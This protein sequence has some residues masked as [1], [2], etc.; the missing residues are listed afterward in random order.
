MADTGNVTGR[1]ETKTVTIDTNLLDKEFFAVNWDASVDNV[2]NIG[3]EDR[4]LPVRCHRK[5]RPGW[6]FG[7]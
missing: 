6:P 1:V 3:G 4:L 7:R 5:R 2:V